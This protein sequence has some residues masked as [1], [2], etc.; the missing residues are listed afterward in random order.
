MD[1]EDKTNIKNVEYV[2]AMEAYEKCV[3]RTFDKIK[4]DHISFHRFLHSNQIQNVCSVELNKMKE[5]V[6]GDGLS[7]SKLV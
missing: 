6:N 1:W 7:Y 5:I 2:D 3:N 4:K